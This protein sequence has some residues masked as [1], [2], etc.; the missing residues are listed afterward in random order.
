MSSILAYANLSNVELARILTV[1][2]A[3]Y[4]PAASLLYRSLTCCFPPGLDEQRL[5]VD[6]GSKATLLA[7]TKELE[8]QFAY[9]R[10]PPT[11][12]SN[13]VNV[14]VLPNLENLTV[15]G[16]EVM[17]TKAWN[18]MTLHPFL[19]R[20]QPTKDLKFVFYR[21][22][23]HSKYIPNI[24]TAV[25]E[26]SRLATSVI[27]EHKDT[28]TL[29]VFSS[30]LD[31]KLRPQVTSLKFG[32][33]I[34]A[35]HYRKEHIFTNI[36][37]GIIALVQRTPQLSITLDIRRTDIFCCLKR[38]WSDVRLYAGVSRAYQQIWFLEESK[39][40][41][42]LQCR[43]SMNFE[44]ATGCAPDDA[45]KSCAHHPRLDDDSSRWGYLDPESDDED[46]AWSGD[47]GSDGEVSSLRGTVVNK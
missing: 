16:D 33:I 34:T 44:E 12:G 15:T 31:I 47:E 13:P 18:E 8:I 36:C 10:L 5:F 32:A 41:E 17:S 11:T 20:L 43:I 2:K 35:D 3:F 46:S 25:T 26:L 38:Q 4:H 6:C 45:P 30:F 1:S 22:D 27:F 37:E 24:K 21:D 19:H 28:T 23:F 9:P 7:H 29:K 42:E 14:A 39:L 40:D